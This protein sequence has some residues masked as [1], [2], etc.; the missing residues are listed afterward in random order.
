MLNNKYVPLYHLTFIELIIITNKLSVEFE[1]NA[2][3]Y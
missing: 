3:S 1:I 2:S